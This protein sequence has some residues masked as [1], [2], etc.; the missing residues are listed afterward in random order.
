MQQSLSKKKKAPVLTLFQNIF[1]RI[2]ALWGIITFII[3]FLIIFI[4]SMLSY[5]V[6]GN[7]GQAYF[8]AVSRWWMNV[9]LILIG[10]PA[11]ILGREHFKEGENYVV[12]YNHNALLD[13]PLSAP[14]VP[15]PNKTIAKASF[16]KVPIFGQFYKRG[17]VLVDRKN[18][19]SR[20]RSYEQMMKV[21]A[22]GMHMCLYPEGT[23]NRTNLPLK[24]FYDGAFKLAV[25]AKKD[26]IPCIIYGTNKAMP[27]HKKFFLK[28]VKLKMQFLPAVSSAD[29]SAKELKEKIYSIMM[30]ALL[31]LPL[32]VQHCFKILVAIIM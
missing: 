5:L 18:E 29:T 7:K 2:W 9:W 23:R 4:P 27:I 30:E 3:T 20:R 25:D 14:Y 1:G 24:Q 28:P 19:I 11:K 26:V 31:T 15:G 17:A 21:L 22:S 13:A 12:V 8:I 10:C 32:V 16:A 6:P